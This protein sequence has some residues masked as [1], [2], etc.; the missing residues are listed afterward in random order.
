MAQ[1]K[2]IETFTGLFFFLSFIILTI[3]IV[4]L[5]NVSFHKMGI[6]L[7]TPFAQR[8]LQIG[9]YQDGKYYL[10]RIFIVLLVA[11][12]VFGS[13]PR[14]H[15]NNSDTTILILKGA[16]ATAIFIF[17]YIL[18]H[19]GMNIGIFSIYTILSIGGYFAMIYYYGEIMT[20]LNSSFGKDRFGK[21]GRRFQQTTE[22][23]ENENSVN[24]KTEDGWINVVNPYRASLVIGTPGSGKTFAV[25]NPAIEQHIQK[26]FAMCVYDYKFPTLSVFTYNCLQEFKKNYKVEPEFCVINF[27]D[28]KKS[29]RCNP[30]Q[31]QLIED[32][33]D[34][35][36]L[37]QAI[38]IALNRSWNSK[39]GDFF[40]ESPINYVSCLIWA[41]RTAEGGRYCSLPHLIELLSKDYDQQFKFLA[42]IEDG[43]IQNMAA[44]FLSAYE[45]EAT[46]QL[47]GQIASARL[48]LSR[49]TSP[50]VYW[51]MSEE[52]D[53]NGVAVDGIDLKIND[54]QKPKVLCIGNNPKRDKVYGVC[55]SL[56]TTKMLK[57]INVKHQ[58]K[59]ALVFDELTTMSFP[60][61]TLDNVI[62]TGRSNKIATWLGFQD[63]QQAVRDF[64]KENAESIVN[65]IGNIFSGSVSGDTAQ[66]LARMFGKIKVKKESQSVSDSGTSISYSEQMEDLIP[67]SEINT[68]SQGMFCGK[69]SDDF[70]QEIEQKFFY[71]TIQ[72][73]L[74]RMAKL[75]EGEIPDLTHFIDAQGQNLTDEQIRQV[76]YNNFNKIKNDITELVERTI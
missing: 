43:T 75:E 40:V 30:L 15:V 74:K 19:M 58:N 51:I 69:V 46:D 14:K 26:G 27:D 64:S 28:P 66:R 16:I 68:L 55:I 52:L 12:A 25:L 50:V 73:D 54:P 47:E 10:V 61:G 76:L 8:I 7:F 48:T 37:A 56:F 72:V 70:G 2:G 32:P 6:D 57:I 29:H 13:K 34:A 65:T 20:T 21:E 23:I 24:I 38:M 9:L 59:C 42:S 39:E 31:P 1:D 44:P 60:K 49:L 18:Y 53:H 67:E 3:D 62:A 11:F 4:T 33:V 36:E 17:S 35:V 63:I 5:G 71:S 41:L 22:K 45:R